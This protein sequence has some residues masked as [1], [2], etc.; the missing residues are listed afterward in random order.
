MT[1][2]SIRHRVLHYA[3]AP[4]DPPSQSNRL[5]AMVQ[6]RMLDETSGTGVRSVW[7]VE[8]N[9]ADLTPRLVDDGIIGLLGHPARVFRDATSPLPLRLDVHATGYLPLTQTLNLDPTGTLP[10]RLG[11]L[12]MHRLPLML[13]GLVTSVG[14]P[15]VGAGVT[16]LE[17]WR[18]PPDPE[19]ATPGQAANLVS[20]RPGLHAAPVAGLLHRR[21]VTPVTG[22]DMA[23][24]RAN[25]PGGLRLYSTDRI[26]LAAGDWIDLEPENAERS[27]FHRIAS[28]RGSGPAILDL[29]Y[30]LHHAHRPGALLRRVTLGAAGPDHVLAD[31]DAEAPENGGGDPDLGI[32]GDRCVFLETLDGLDAA[33]AVE[34]VAGTHREVQWM[35]PYSTETDD[36]GRFRLPPLGRVAQVRL[37]AEGG[38]LTEPIEGRFGLRYSKAVQTIE[39]ARR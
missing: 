25:P 26:N 17:I 5:H 6:A 7:A 30:P 39:L 19:A 16:L 2:I 12:A 20:I 38:G 14:E 23:L 31:P 4:D 33:G 11:D 8:S 36:R 37:H 21:A 24:A 32:P 3:F 22:E 28:I 29:A 10:H 27:E 15:V 13:Q 35:Q 9:V 18:T 1:P 34:V